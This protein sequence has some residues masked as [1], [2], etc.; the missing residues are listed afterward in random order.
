VAQGRAPNC[1]PPARCTSR[2]TPTANTCST[3]WANAYEQHGLAYYPKALV[4]PPFTPVPGARLLA[5]DADARRRWCRR[6][7]SW[8]DE[9]AVVPAP[10]VCSGRRRGRLRAAGLMLRHTVQFHWT[11]PTLGHYSDFDDF[12][13]S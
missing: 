8:C 12:L 3:A 4:A 1:T 9:E 10:A 5:R 13:A 2:P 7:C 11:K 6:W